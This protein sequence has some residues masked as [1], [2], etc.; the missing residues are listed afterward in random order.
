MPRLRFSHN[1]PHSTCTPRT[2]LRPGHD[3]LTSKPVA[4][5]QSGPQWTQTLDRA[6]RSLLPKALSSFAL[7]TPYSTVSSAT[8]LA[9]PA[10]GP[11][12]EI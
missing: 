1:Y 3:R 11:T 10:G 8:A 9:A 7:V 5:A 12:D 2:P 4:P 6:D